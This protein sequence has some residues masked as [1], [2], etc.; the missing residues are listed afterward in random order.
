[1]RKIKKGKFNF[2]IL[3]LFVILISISLVSSTYTRTVTSGA[4]YA[5][6]SGISGYGSTQSLHFDKS[7]CGERGQ[8]LLVQIV[9]FGC[10]PSVVRSDL[11]E[12][13]DVQVLCQLGATQINPLIDIEA[14]DYMTITG[15]YPREVSSVGY[16]PSQAALGTII[17]NELELTSPIL[18]NLGYVVI[19]LRRQT[20]ESAMPDY[21]SGNLTAKIRY[22]IKSAFGVGNANFYL[23][24]LTD[25]EW[26][27]KYEQYSFWQGRGYLRAISTDDNGAQIA[28]YADDSIVKSGAFSKEGKTYSK[29]QYSSFYLKKGEQSTELYLPGFSPCLA[30]LNVKLG[31]LINPDTLVKLK[32]G[33]DY[34][35][36]KKGEKFLDNNCQVK[37][38]DKNG[39]Y[40]SVKVYCNDDEKPWLMRYIS[41]YT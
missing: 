26:N 23:P 15:D 18:S 29:T 20:N 9:P 12:D 13:Q 16:F 22:D 19:N 2:G 34:V 21:V 37:S 3:F 24:V 31:D 35:E 28:V 14:I 1:M 40:Q 39:L 8:D 7:M 17:S 10:I 25:E 38:I 4:Q 11:L 5:L 33:S 32:I 36:V 27:E 30:T 6:T 41:K